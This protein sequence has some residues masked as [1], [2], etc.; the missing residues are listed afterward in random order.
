MLCEKPLTTN[1]ADAE[2]MIA[3]AENNSVL[4][5]MASKFRY[6]DDV[7][8][9]KGILASGVLGDVLQFENAFTA[10]VECPSDGIPSRDV[11]RR[12]SC[13]DNGTHSVDIIRYFIGG[14]ESVLVVEPAAPRIKVDENVK[15]F[16][17]TKTMSPRVSI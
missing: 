6:C 16:A 11:G 3:T 7:I 5:T 12:T 13:I 17:K 14:I 10:K 4:F 15:M 8:K 1:V 9:A 2:K